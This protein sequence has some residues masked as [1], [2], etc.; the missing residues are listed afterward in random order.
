[1]PDGGFAV[2]V[3]VRM[4]LLRPSNLNLNSECAMPEGCRLATRSLLFVGC[5]QTNSCDVL[6][7]QITGYTVTTVVSAVHAADVRWVS[8]AVSSE[9]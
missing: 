8:H 7:Q 5:F 3:E 4:P 6:R 1:M 2:A 9:K